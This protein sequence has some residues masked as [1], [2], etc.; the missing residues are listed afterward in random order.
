MIL[1]I[2][3]DSPRR[4]HCGKEAE[5]FFKTSRGTLWPLCRHCAALHKKLALSIA[6][7]GG[8]P[9]NVLAGATFDIPLDNEK[10]QIEYARQDPETLKEVLRLADRKGDSD[11]PGN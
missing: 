8:V 7:K 5:S 10:A 2:F 1:C 4:P 3:H 9:L 11:P 6:K